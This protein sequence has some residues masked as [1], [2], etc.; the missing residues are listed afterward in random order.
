M[1]PLIYFFVVFVFSSV[2]AEIPLEQEVYITN[3]NLVDAEYVFTIGSL[4][5]ASMEDGALLRLEP[6]QGLENQ[7]FIIS[8]RNGYYVI[9]AKHSGKL[10][11]AV[12]DNNYVIQEHDLSCNP[13]TEYFEKSQLFSILV[14]DA[15]GLN[16]CFYSFSR[17]TLLQFDFDFDYEIGR[18]IKLTDEVIQA[19]PTYGDPQTWRFLKVNP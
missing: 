15:V 3:K 17:A 10:L 6:N 5:D 12:E 9:K 11:T 14:R 16:Y 7:K 2:V 4:I 8:E 1:N 18:W 19:L 13:E